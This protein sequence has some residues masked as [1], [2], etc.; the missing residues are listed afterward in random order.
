MFTSKL[1]SVPHHLN[2]INSLFHL[3]TEIFTLFLLLTETGNILIKFNVFE[4]TFENQ[5]GLR[6]VI[7]K[8]QIVEGK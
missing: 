6:S 2:L 1:N 8:L 3:Q 7:F 5:L 4:N